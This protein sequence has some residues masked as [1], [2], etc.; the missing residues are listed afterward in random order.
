MMRKLAVFLTTLLLCTQNVEAKEI[1]T[2]EEIG[3]YLTKENPYVYS[4]VGQQYVDEARVQT[5]MGSFDTK[6]SSQYD[7][8]EFPLSDGR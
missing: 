8:K 3:R 4:A 1:F 2:A 7:K 6:L 5:A